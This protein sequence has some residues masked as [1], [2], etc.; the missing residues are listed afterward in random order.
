MLGHTSAQVITIM[1][2]AMCVAVACVQVARI[3][4]AEP[5][6]NSA[7]LLRLQADLGGG[8]TRQVMAGADR[9]AA[10]LYISCVMY[11]VSCML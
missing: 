10:F 11:C 2:A 6:E 9:V 4:S 1:Y 7:K 3:V 8:D 5:L